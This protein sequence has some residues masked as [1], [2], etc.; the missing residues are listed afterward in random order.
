MITKQ[1]FQNQLPLETR[2][3]IQ[4][5]ESGRWNMIV[6]SGGYGKL[7]YIILLKAFTFRCFKNIMLIT[8]WAISLKLLYRVL[9]LDRTQGRPKRRMLDIAPWSTCLSHSQSFLSLAGYT[10]LIRVIISVNFYSPAELTYMSHKEEI[11]P[12]WRETYF[13]FK[14][15]LSRLRTPCFHMS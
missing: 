1:V 5:N 13:R 14:P 11:G 15:V 12:K 7:E 9:K 3:T 4:M 10:T 6:S 2:R 8:H